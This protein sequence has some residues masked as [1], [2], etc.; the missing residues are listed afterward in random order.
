VTPK[1]KRKQSIGRLVRTRRL[2]LR[3]TQATA[4]E[5]AGMTSQQWSDVE[6]DRYVAPSL[7]TLARVGLALGCGVE[8]LL[9]NNRPAQPER[10]AP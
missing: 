2:A 9:P 8:D 1:T 6:C 10:R 5:R 4:A 3:V 7:T